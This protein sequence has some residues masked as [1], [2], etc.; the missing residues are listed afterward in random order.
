LFVAAL[1]AGGARF[2]DEGLL[3]DRGLFLGAALFVGWVQVGE[4][5]GASGHEDR[6]SFLGQDGQGVRLRRCGFAGRRCLGQTG[7]AGRTGIVEEALEFG[8]EAE[9]GEFVGHPDVGFA[10][11]GVFDAGAEIAGGDD[12]TGGSADDAGEEMVNFLQAESD[13]FGAGLLECFDSS[14]DVFP[15]QEAAPAGGGGAAN[16]QMSI[17]D[18]RLI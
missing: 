14:D 7:G 15:A 5:L 17:A 16:C 8:G 2:W 10:V 6:A 12:V 4:G 1:I 11:A 9:A 18:C 13:D 3:F